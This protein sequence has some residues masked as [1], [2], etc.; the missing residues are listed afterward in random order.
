MK[1]PLG[2][3][4]SSNATATLVFARSGIEIGAAS[5]PNSV[6]MRW[7]SVKWRAGVSCYRVYSHFEGLIWTP[8]NVVA[9]Q[10][11]LLNLQLVSKRD[12]VHW[13]LRIHARLT[14]QNET[15]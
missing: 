2:P 3:S 1:L 14:P 11:S 4:A 6:F 9:G 13:R 8:P 15:G 5:E 7:F 10:A 12:Q